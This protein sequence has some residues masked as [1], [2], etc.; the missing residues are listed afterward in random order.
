MCVC[1]YVCEYTMLLDRVER[2]L[3]VF[4]WV[5]TKMLWTRLLGQW[6]F[7]AVVDPG[8]GEEPLAVL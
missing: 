5:V 7:K 2:R 8:S 3:W 4:V 1:V 6:I